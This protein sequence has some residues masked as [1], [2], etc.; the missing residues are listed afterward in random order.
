MIVTETIANRLAK[1][2]AAGKGVD[3]KLSQA[4]IRKQA[5]AGWLTGLLPVAKQLFKKSIMPL[6]KKVIGPLASGALSGLS[7]WTTGKILGSG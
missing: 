7:S 1:A 3:I 2:K 4:A 6:A 5:G